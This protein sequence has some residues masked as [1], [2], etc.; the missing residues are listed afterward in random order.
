[1]EMEDHG[2][3]NCVTLGSYEGVTSSDRCVHKSDEENWDEGVVSPTVL[4][5]S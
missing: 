1:M 5:F 3:S 2:A 4:E